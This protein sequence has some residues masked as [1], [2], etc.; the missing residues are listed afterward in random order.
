MAVTV[1]MWYSIHKKDL[2]TKIPPMKLPVI[3]AFCSLTGTSFQVTA[4]L[5]LVTL[6]ALNPSGDPA[7]SV[8]IRRSNAFNNLC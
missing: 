4:M 2:L 7:G 5:L 3:S 1:L 6:T 8:G